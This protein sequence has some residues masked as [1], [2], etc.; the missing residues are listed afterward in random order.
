[1]YSI[2]AKFQLNSSPS[3]SWAK[4]GHARHQKPMGGWKKG[5][6]PMPESHWK[7]IAGSSGGRSLPF[8]CILCHSKF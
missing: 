3:E 7:I 2:K 6:E 1:M 8:F 4:I 5:G